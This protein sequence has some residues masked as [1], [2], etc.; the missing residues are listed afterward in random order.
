[1][2]VDV[3]AELAAS[4]VTGVMHIQDIIVSRWRE[5]SADENHQMRERV[6]EILRPLGIEIASLL[7]RRRANSIA[8]FFICMMPPAVATLRDQWCTKK[9]R[10]A[11]QNLFSLL[12]DCTDSEVR[13]KRLTWLQS[14]YE[15]C[16]ESFHCLQ[17]KHMIID[18][19]INFQERRIAKAAKLQKRHCNTRGILLHVVES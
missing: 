1:V 3:D 12:S 4:L 8:L 5:V 16:L 9:L 11:V 15:R 6:D 2:V 19:V 17:G 7:L 10:Q 14:H 18:Q 13:V